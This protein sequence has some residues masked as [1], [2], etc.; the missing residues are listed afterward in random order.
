[1]DEIAHLPGF[2]MQS[3][4]QAY[5]AQIAEEDAELASAKGITVVTTT[6]LSHTWHG[7]GQA[8][9]SGPAH[10]DEQLLALVEGY[11]K[12]NLRLLHRHG[13]KLAIGSD[14][15]ETSLP[16]AMNLFRLGVFDNLTLLKMWAETTPQ[17]IFPSRAIGALEEGR[18]ASFL[19]LNCNPINDF[20]CV[21]KIQLRVKQGSI[22]DQTN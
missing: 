11:Q 4:E 20:S 1:V 5:R 16:E 18:E 10:V 6:R 22:L 8:H 19:V 14:H 21:E 17:A 7:G 15:D 13:V 12:R 3:P 2:F 9:G